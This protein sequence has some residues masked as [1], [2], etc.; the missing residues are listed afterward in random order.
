MAMLVLPERRTVEAWEIFQQRDVLPAP[1]KSVS[2]YPLPLNFLL[3]F[4]LLFSVAVSL[5]LFF[6]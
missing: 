5:S 6:S 1:K 2:H 3:L 4:Q